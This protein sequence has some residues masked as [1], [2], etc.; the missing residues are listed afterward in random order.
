MAHRVWAS[1][2]PVIAGVLLGV[3]T[4]GCATNG[5]DGKSDPREKLAGGYLSSAS[6]VHSELDMHMSL[7]LVA[8]GRDCGDND[9]DSTYHFEQRVQEIGERLSQATFAKYPELSK[10]FEKFEFVVADKYDAGAKSSGAGTIVILRG[11]ERLGFDDASLAFIMAREMAHVVAGHYESNML[12]SIAISIVV[13]LVMPVFN[14]ARG[15]A[16]VA[17]T[18]P[19]ASTLA[20]SAASMAGN[21]ALRANLRP[22][23][24]REAEEMGMEILVLSG[25]DAK[26]VVASLQTRV[27]EFP[28]EEAWVLELRGSVARVAKMTA[29]PMPETYINAKQSMLAK[30]IEPTPLPVAF[31]APV[32]AAAPTVIAATVPPPANHRRNE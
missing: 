20:G 17:S 12:T 8:N 25:Y 18:S 10:R 31:V 2:L 27:T 28:L 22:G 1:P 14:F 4:S 26:E 30:V 3:A 16:A 19:A 21:Q 15:A 23:Q 32:P 6:A 9:C 13:Q 29:G 5:I 24:L 11:V 7:L